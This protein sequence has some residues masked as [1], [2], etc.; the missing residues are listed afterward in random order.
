MSKEEIPYISRPFEAISWLSIERKMSISFPSPLTDEIINWFENHS[1]SGAHAIG[2]MFT[3]AFYY[4]AYFW[5]LEIPLAF[6]MVQLNALDALRQMPGVIKSQLQGDIATMGRFIELW[7]DSMDY[8]YGIDDLGRGTRLP[9]IGNQQFAA[10]L[11]ASA[12]RELTASVR[13]LTESRSPNTKALE[14]GRMATEMFLKAY[15]AVHTSLT[16]DEAQKKFG[17][18]LEKLVPECK[19]VRG[20]ADFDVLAQYMKVFPPF[21]ARY[22]G[23]DYGN[24]RLWSGYA[25]ALRTGVMFTR[26]LTDRDNRAKLEAEFSPA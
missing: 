2:S 17:H 5:K 4:D 15:L 21:G 23:V 6:G 11:T 22:E 26:S 9:V 7:V 1:P 13:L 14:T 19:S 16:R 12:H 25:V 18:N 10:E 3:S 24:Q 8:A 20:H